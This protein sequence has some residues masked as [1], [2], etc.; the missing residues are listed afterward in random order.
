V[1]SIY[2]YRETDNC[3]GKEKLQKTYGQNSKIEERKKNAKTYYKRSKK[4]KFWKLKG[5][6]FVV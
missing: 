4:K 6:K 1:I 3:Q 2:V 5:R